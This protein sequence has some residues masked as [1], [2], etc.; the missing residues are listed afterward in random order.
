METL[1]WMWIWECHTNLHYFLDFVR[2]EH[3][4]SEI[5]K[6]PSFFDKIS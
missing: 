5:S 3:E 4:I 1:N 2:E 6:N